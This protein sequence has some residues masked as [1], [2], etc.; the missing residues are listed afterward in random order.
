MIFGK[1]ALSLICSLLLFSVSCYAGEPSI[2]SDINT[3]DTLFPNIELN[4]N[5]LEQNLINLE[6]NNQELSQSLTQLQNTATQMKNTLDKQCL[7]LENYEHKYHFWKKVG[8]VSGITSIVCI[9]STLI[10][11]TNK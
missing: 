1:R 8:I 10:V 7:Q 9:T 3:I 2:S 6:K 11:L 5:N 4:L